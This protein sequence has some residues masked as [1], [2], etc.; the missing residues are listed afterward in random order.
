M[1]IFNYSTLIVCLLALVAFS[2]APKYGAHFNKTKSN[3]YKPAVAVETEKSIETTHSDEAMEKIGRKNV[4]ASVENEVYPEAPSQI[5]ERLEKYKA[6]TE[7][8]KKKDLSKKEEKKA[9]KKEKKKLKKDLRR[10]IKKEVKALKKDEV[11]GDYVLMMILAIIIPPLGVGLTYGLTAE[12]W[13][14]LLLT[15]I[16][17]LPGAIYSVIVVHNYFR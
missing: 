5:R 7:A 16:F 8:I 6:K 13:I 15:L 1:K 2:C 4:V 14:S 11:E 10:E 17:W 9:I 12:F 3:F